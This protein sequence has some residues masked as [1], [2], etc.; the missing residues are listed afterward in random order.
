VSF[1]ETSRW[2]D[3][4]DTAST[5]TLGLAAQT[6]DRLIGARNRSDRADLFAGVA[7]AFQRALVRLSR[8]NAARSCSALS[9]PA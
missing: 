6:L 2:P 4:G 3:L 5:M 8:E 1:G 9:R 7:G